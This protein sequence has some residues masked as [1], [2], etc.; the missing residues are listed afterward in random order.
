[1]TKYLIAGVLVLLVG[2]GLVEAW[3]LLKGPALVIDS[4]TPGAVFPGAIASVSGK[5]LRAS[6][7]TLD[8]APLLPDEQGAFSA[9]LTFP[10]GSSILTF[11]AADRFGRSIIKTRQIF[12]PAGAPVGSPTSDIGAN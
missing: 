10:R 11:V 7:L 9:T 5:V 4:P 1:M 2:Y 3:P 12:V 8:G 6:A